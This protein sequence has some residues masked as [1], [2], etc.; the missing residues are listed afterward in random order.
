MRLELRGVRDH[1][2]EK[3][4]D[5]YFRE[6]YEL[7]QEKAKI[8]SLIVRYRI[9][10]KLTQGQLARKIRVTQQQISKIEQ[11]D[12]SSL[13]TIQK[14]LIALGYHVVVKA[15]PLDPRRRRAVRTAA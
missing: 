1:L 7:E 4:K 10:H 2:A 15:E 14:V 9:Q 12:F 3:A 6:L 13:V 8:A 11:G 5:P